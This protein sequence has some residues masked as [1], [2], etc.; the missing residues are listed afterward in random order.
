MIEVYIGYAGIPFYV[1]FKEGEEV[2][3]GWSED[4]VFNRFGVRVDDMKRIGGSDE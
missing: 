4:E 1:V 3:Y 2:Y